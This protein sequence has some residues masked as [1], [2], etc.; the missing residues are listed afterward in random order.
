[1]ERLNIIMCNTCNRF[2]DLKGWKAHKLTKYHR[3]QRS[4]II[5]RHDILNDPPIPDIFI[6]IDLDDPNEV[7]EYDK[8]YNLKDYIYKRHVIKIDRK[9]IN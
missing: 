7:E 3:L 6:E 5:S 9:I 1:M 4:Y 8:G 2:L